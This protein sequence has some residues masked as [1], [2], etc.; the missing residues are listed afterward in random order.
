M[1]TIELSAGHRS[2][3]PLPQVLLWSTER[4]SV[5]RKTWGGVLLQE[6]G[7]GLAG[8]QHLSQCRVSRGQEVLTESLQAGAVKSRCPK[9]KGDIEA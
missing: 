3:P 9:A 6:L 4:F 7:V 8:P 1:A 2:S 5:R